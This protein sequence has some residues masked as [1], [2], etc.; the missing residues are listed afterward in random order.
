LLSKIVALFCFVIGAACTLTG[1]ASPCVLSFV[2]S[3]D[4]IWWKGVEPIFRKSE[5]SLV[6]QEAIPADFLR[7]I[8]ARPETIVV[9]AHSAELPWERSKASLA[10]FKRL[11]QEES[12]N[13][14]SE[15]ISDLKQRISLLEATTPKRT[16]KGAEGLLF[17]PQVK[18]LILLK[19]NLHRIQN[20]PDDKTLY[21]APK[22]I[23]P[24]VF[25]RLVDE[26]QKQK[27]RDS[28]RLRL[29]KIMIATCNSQKVQS[30]YRREFERLREDFGIEVIFSPDNKLMSLVLGR[31]VSYP[32]RKWLQESLFF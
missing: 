29:K 30:R 15:E 4:P 20:I 22:L 19:R 31:E 13:A 3:T 25:E 2:P 1:Q 18:S 28:G 27:E 10:Y 14:I 12:S 17:D 32:K 21:S 16:V 8:E 5:H 26:L 11:S 23:M 6:I 9:V 24:L 7:C